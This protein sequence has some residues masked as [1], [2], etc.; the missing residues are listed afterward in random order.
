MSEAEHGS[1][2]RAPT[3]LASNAN[4]ISNFD[5]IWPVGFGS[6]NGFFD[7]LQL[8][9]ELPARKVINAPA[10]LAL[11]HGKAAWAEH[12]PDH[13]IAADAS[14]LISAMQAE[15]G[16]WVLK[17]LAGSFGEGVRHL[18]SDEAQT[19]TEAMS[20][21]PGEYFMLQRF[22]RRS[23]RGN[24]HISGRRSPNWQLPPRTDR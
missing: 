6:R 20:A 1:I 18:R 5:L 8:M 11:K 16:E 22:C 10:A 24:P 7:W 2:H 23:R 19:I 17:P 13:Y 14:T 3:G 12:C 21:R 15:P 4:P 9:N